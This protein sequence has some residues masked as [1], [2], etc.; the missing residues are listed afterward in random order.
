MIRTNNKKCQYH[1]SIPAE[2]RKEQQTRCPKEPITNT[3]GF[4]F[5]TFVIVGLALCEEHYKQVLDWID[6]VEK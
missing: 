6:D 1:L 3:A 2:Q 4:D 5:C